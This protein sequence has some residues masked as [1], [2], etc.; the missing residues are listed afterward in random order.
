MYLSRTK[1][2]KFKPL[3]HDIAKKFRLALQENKIK[4]YYTY[5]SSKHTLQYVFIDDTF[6]QG[7]FVVNSEGEIDDIYNPTIYPTLPI[8]FDFII[9]LYEKEKSAS[10]DT[11]KSL[12]P[13]LYDEEVLKR[14]MT[15]QEIE[16]YDNTKQNFKELINSIN[17]N[18]EEISEE[19]EELFFT[20]NLEYN[21]YTDEI[22]YD[23]DSI[24]VNNKRKYSLNTAFDRFILKGYPLE[25]KSRQLLFIFSPLYN[26]DSY[27]YHSSQVTFTRKVIG[28]GI[29]ALLTQPI[30]KSSLKP[31]SFNNEEY[32]L[33]S[34]IKNIQV[35]IDKDGNIVSPYLENENS[36]FFDFLTPKEIVY[37]DK[38]KHLATYICLSSDVEKQL[39]LFKSKNP[40]FNSTLFKKEITQSL[41]PTVKNVVSIE[42]NFLSNTLKQIDHIEYYIDLDKDNFELICKSMYFMDGKETSY[43]EYS[44]KYL[45][46]TAAFLNQ[47]HELQLPIKGNVKEDEIIAN[48]VNS[49]LNQLKKTC[50]VFVSEDFKKLKKKSVA[51]INIVIESNQDWLSINF[52]SN[53]YSQKEI[54]SILAA[55]K[56]KKKYYRLKDEILVLDEGYGKDMISLLNDFDIN[57]KKVPIYQALKLKARQDV[58]MSK[59]I[60]DLFDKIQ[61]YDDQELSLDENILKSL[62]P[63]QIKGVKWLTALKENKL[64][65]I[66]ADDMGLGKSFELIAFLSQY[67]TNKPNL[68]V[69]PK[70]LTYN[71]EKEFKQWN[72]SANVVVLSTSKEDRHA[73][74]AKLQTDNTTYIISYD[75]L[76]IDLDYFKDKEFSF[77]ILDEGQYISN[78]LSK[79]SR[80]VKTIN[81]D[82]K[83]ALTGTPIQNSLM[84]LWSIFDFLMPGYLKSFSEFKNIYGKFDLTQESRTHLENIVSPFLLKRKKDDV[85]TELPGKTTIAQE[86]IMDEKEQELYNAYL[87]K[88]RQML[89]EKKGKSGGIEILSALTRLRQLCVDPSIFLDFDKTSSKLEYTISLIK[90][91]VGKNHKILLFSSFTTVLDHLGLLLDKEN[92]SHDTIQGSTSATKRIKL[93][94]DFNTSDNIKV[95]L[96]SLK[97]GGT[98]LNLI[99][100]DIV[101]HLDPWWNLA[102]EDQASD[103]AYRIGQTRKVIIYKLVMKNTIEEKVLELQD[104]KKD[105][106][107]I[108]DNINSRTALSDDDIKFLLN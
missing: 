19:K 37:F 62:R 10:E 45:E 85:L 3:N 81:A 46:N 103:R 86:L 79:K 108:F 98:G 35:Y 95:M 80:A 50:Q 38:T 75:S 44:K 72:P 26:K 6:G 90:E 104:K 34:Q 51:R 30:I 14:G 76:R 60:K 41:V 53:D 20:I 71:W 92:I 84:D 15:K 97:A 36:F 93:V 87:L 21:E 105:L 102:A 54:D 63:Y 101:I 106:S 70:S 11:L 66:L 82:Y 47:L 96:I 49:P 74:L 61:N 28:Q 5:N 57:Q 88:T 17:T 68:L 52:Q 16:E 18:E 13:D 48:I 83:F 78:A 24:S 64:S 107:D 67:H 89:G 33:D 40:M 31:L 65:G 9:Y 59:E 25:E 69:C 58:K 12:Y 43:D 8:V 22:I 56:K 32:N 100:A 29:K 27:Q 91:A 42:Q 39:L 4:I 55:Y 1:I 94:D 73:K 7:S 23:I 2:Q 77:L 99:G